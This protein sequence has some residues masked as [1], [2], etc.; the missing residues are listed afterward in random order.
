MSSP[1]AGCGLASSTES[2]LTP[3]TC[4][5]DRGRVSDV[6]AVCRQAV[7]DATF[8]QSAGSALPFD[9]PAAAAFH[10]LSEVLHRGRPPRR[11]TADLMI[12]ATARVSRAA[13]VHGQPGRLR[14]HRRPARRGAGA[15]VTGP[16]KLIE[17]AL[18][19]DAINREA[20]REKSIRR[21]HPLD[22]A[23]VVGPPAA[24]RA[25][26]FARFVDDPSAHPG[27]FFTDGAR[28]GPGRD[29]PL[30]PR[31]PAPGRGP[32]RRWRLDPVGGATARP[33]SPRQRP[34]PVT[35]RINKALISGLRIE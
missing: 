32:F 26:L 21:G 3:S 24:C 8:A 20:A 34:Q 5:G 17:V 15:A 22:A 12:A 7:L 18:P 33:G 1:N 35:V 25:V 19:L 11:H 31:R 10:V 14:R 2:W 16:K 13:G 27:W 29:P 6:V 28:G 4:D 30:L 9:E 23:P